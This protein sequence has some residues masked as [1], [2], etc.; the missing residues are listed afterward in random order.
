MV[1][2]ENICKSFDGAE[3]LK[4]L[5]INFDDK[6]ITVVIGRSGCGKTIMLKHILGLVKPDSG[7]VL[8]DGVDLN[9]IDRKE[10]NELRKKFGMVFQG[11][12]LF[13]SLNIFENVAFPLRQHF[14]TVFPLKQHAELRESE[15]KKRVLLKLD[16]VGLRNSEYKMPA[17]ISGGMMKRVAVARALILEP[18][19]VL[20]DEPTTGLDPIMSDVINNLIISTQRKFKHTCIVISHNIAEAYKIGDSIAMLYDGAIIEI[21]D[22]EVFKHSENPIIRQFVSGSMTGPIAI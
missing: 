20:F 4:N 17:E 10:L 8:I 15:I 12:A 18:E 19:I 13:D 21:G 1:V 16:E 3:V 2:L 22:V 9:A 5:N 7:R 6:K 11:G 14:K